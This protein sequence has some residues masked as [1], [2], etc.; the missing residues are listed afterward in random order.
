[1]RSEDFTCPTVREAWQAHNKAL[2]LFSSQL[3]KAA[4]RGLDT[5]RLELLVQ[6]HTV[7]VECLEQAQQI[8]N[9]Y[10]ECQR[11]GRED[12]LYSI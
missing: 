5:T 7:C 3:D 1:M 8:T 9:F 2:A 10:H 6:T 4:R 11:Q 12:W